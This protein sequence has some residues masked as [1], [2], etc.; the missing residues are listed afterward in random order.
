[1]DVGVAASSGVG[2]CEGAGTGC[3]GGSRRR[4]VEDRH[5]ACNAERSRGFAFE[6]PDRPVDPVLERVSESV[7]DPAGFR[8]TG[9]MHVPL[10]I[11]QEQFVVIRARHGLPL[12]GDAFRDRLFDRDFRVVG[13]Q[14]ERGS[15]YRVN[16]WN[17]ESE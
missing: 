4:R 6:C 7:R 14:K 8:R 3:R 9:D 11:S 12:K 16:E 1:M 2:V 15:V 5:G 13:R 10:A 17:E